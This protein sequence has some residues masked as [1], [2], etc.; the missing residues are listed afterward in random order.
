M[1]EVWCEPAVARERV[2]GV[3]ER[4]AANGGRVEE[5]VAASVAHLGMVA[6]VVSPLLGLTAVQGG[7]PELE[8]ADLWWQPL[9]GGVFPLS[10]PRRC[11]R[12]PRDG[13][14]A[15]VV[16]GA[17]R[18][19]VEVFAGLSVSRRVLWGNVASAVHGAAVAA[20]AADPSRAPAVR[21]AASAVLALPELREAFDVVND[22]FR[23][24]SCCLIYRTA[25]GGT[26]ALCGDCV[27]LFPRT[28]R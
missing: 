20:H 2:A 23:R 9:L 18:Q 6:R 15:A 19:L 10:L 28:A 11:A 5:R 1:G 24:R 12:L 22:R 3:R 16:G 21:R 26:R 7:V 17:V 8:L 13:G 27:L 14:P 4:L 25:P